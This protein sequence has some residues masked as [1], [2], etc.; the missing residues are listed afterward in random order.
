MKSKLLPTLSIGAVAAC[1]MLVAA[2]TRA[3][4]KPAATVTTSVTH[5]ATVTKID[6]QTR[7][8]TL[9]MDDGGTL[10]IEAGPEVKNFAQIKVGDK[11]SFTQA[12]TVSIEVVPAGQAAPN[13]TGGSSTVTAPLG[14]KPMGVKVDTIT[15]SGAVTAIDYGKRLVSVKGPKGN[16]Q[17]FE[18]GKA[19]KN[20]QNV[21]V[22][23]VVVVT[24]TTATAIQVQAPGK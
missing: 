24:L 18:V 13:V 9:K 1:M 16:T 23:D 7:W 22:G 4:D 17:T 6:A 10:D 21:K 15:V 3:Q 11:V 14:A 19:A 5:T 8:V 20:F 2:S 12:D